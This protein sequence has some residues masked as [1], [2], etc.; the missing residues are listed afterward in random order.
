[1]VAYNYATIDVPGGAGAQPTAINDAG[2]IIGVYLDA[3]DIY[4]AFIDIGGVI[5]AISPAGSLS[6]TYAYAIN[7]LGQVVGNYTNS[8]G[9]FEGFLYSGGAYSTIVPPGSVSV[10]YAINASGQLAGYYTDGSGNYHGF[11]DSGGVYTTID[12]PGST[13]TIA[14]SI[15]S[16]GQI[17]GF[18][19]DSSGNLH[20]FLDSSGIYTTIT[21]PLASTYTSVG[22][23]NNSGEAVGSY[24]DS[25]GNTHGFLDKGGVYTTI[26]GPSSTF[27]VATGINDLGE[28]FGFYNNSNGQHNGFVENGGVFTTI[29]PPGSM[30]AVVGGVNDLG[31]VVGWY[32]DSSGMHGFL[33]T[34]SVLPPIVLPDLAHATFGTTI[35]VAAEGV[36]ADDNPGTTGDTLTVSAVNG[37]SQNV[38]TTVAGAYGTLTLDTDGSFT[39]K[40]SGHSALPLSGVSEDFFGYTALEEGSGGGGSASSTLSVVV[41][42]PGLAYVAAPV[43][44]SATQS[45]G[46]HYALLD[47]SAGNATLNAV[48]GIGA[49]LVGGNS[50]TLKLANIGLD[51]VVAMGNFGQI[52]VD[53]YKANGLLDID[54]IQLSKSDFGNNPAAIAKDATQAPGSPNIVITDPINHDTITLAGVSLSSLHFDA[55]HFLLV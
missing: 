22:G 28:V 52:T 17:A 13:Y 4:Q 50:D 18:Y 41:T 34:S 10:A 23:I 3:S 7:G 26:D 9:N 8:S 38:G 40:A 43:G 42:A 45:N 20:G 14:N 1:M 21:D 25:S 16:S 48:N 12:P 51:T 5:T 39:Y 31:Q 35:H 47:G 54:L 30:N 29:D 49:A 44:G 46:L 36:L 53:N 2:Q 37:L 19:R 15:N 24:I 32:S 11:F 27:T 6:N 55:S 33:A